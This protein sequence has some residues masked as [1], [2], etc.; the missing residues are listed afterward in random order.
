VSRA[1]LSH[2]FACATL[3]WTLCLLVG[4]AA[5]DGAAAP[6]VEIPNDAN[7]SGHQ[8]YERV[9]ANRFESFAQDSKLMSADRAGRTQES[10]FHMKWQDFRE[11]AEGDEK[12]VLSKTVVRYSHPFDLRHAGYLILSNADRA[13]DQFVYYP[14]RR[15]V[16]RVSLRSE[17]V[18]GTD[19]SFEDVVPREAEDFYSERLPNAVL[20]GV[21]VFVVDLSPRDHVDSEYSRI[22]VYVDTQRSVVVHARYWDDAGV[23]IKQLL[24]PADE[25]RNYG[26]VYVPM[27]AT[28]RNLL[29]DS[30]TTLV[31]TKI[32]PNLEFD[33]DT[34][35]LRRLEGH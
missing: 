5:A 13:N 34:W 15:R 9:V 6:S 31:I 25:I 20:D 27:R 26:G 30:Q 24:A 10:R 8:I 29:I 7:L 18:Y 4:S 32:E 28:M 23:E 35:D 3:G 19:F 22:R 1:R 2:T 21:E 12:G 14:S 11:K 16:A 17:A 33:I